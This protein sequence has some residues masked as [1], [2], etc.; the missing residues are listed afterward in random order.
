MGNCNSTNER[1]T[2]LAVKGCSSPVGNRGH[3]NKELKLLCQ[4]HSFVLNGKQIIKY[5]DQSMEYDLYF[6]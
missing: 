3:E 1:S 2:T 5:Y 6:V 4:A